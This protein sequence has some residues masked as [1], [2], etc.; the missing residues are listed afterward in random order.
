MTPLHRR[1]HLGLARAP[2]PAPSGSPVDA[3]VAHAPLDGAAAAEGEAW[4]ALLTVGALAL[5]QQ[6]GTRPQAGGALPPGPDLTQERPVAPAGARLLAQLLAG[7]HRELLP[8]A[9]ERLA[10]AGATLSAELLPAAL[11]CPDPALR[12]R[13]RPVL[14]PRGAWLAAQ[15]PAWA[16]LAGEPALADPEAAWLG[17]DIG[18]RE[19]A[20]RMLRRQDPQEGRVRLLA[21]WAG[22][23][24]E[25]RARLLPAL[26]E[27]LSMLDEPLL[28]DAL[29]D[30]ASAVRAAAARLL[31][32]LPASRWSLRMR[33]RAEDCLHHHAAAAGRL[34]RLLTGPSRVTLHPPDT[35]TRS[36]ARDGLTEPGEHG[37][38]AP[39]WWLVQIL[40]AVPP[41]HWQRRLRVEP[42]ALLA[43]LGPEQWPAVE[44]LS[45]AALSWPEAGWQLP[46]WRWWRA[47]ERGG[48]VRAGR[49]QHW[50][51]DLLRVLGAADAERLAL[52]LLR[53]PTLADASRLNAALERL[54]RPWPA[55][56][57][58][59]WL[60]G[61]HQSLQ[62]VAA[63]SP[64]E[65]LWWELSIQQAGVALPL[66]L[67]TWLPSAEP[68]RVA[69]WRG[70]IQ[71][72]RDQA[73]L[74]QRLAEE[75]HP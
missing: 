50:Q 45:R 36:L 31:A 24:P 26:E 25:D 74:R 8:E 39:E 7:Q 53:E 64:H 71:K 46:L 61:L 42:A 19:A 54:P 73:A 40:A 59:A 32:R 6:G 33:A 34:E 47:Q 23:R 1:L 9:L 38:G 21:S 27:G 67:L 3:L 4:R 65:L 56:V 55:G 37:L 58:R 16:W 30:R 69:R 17:V 68:L 60:T 43:L 70:L 20:L 13:L 44:G 10:Q 63:G 52:E 41:Q 15:N 18:A 2:E 62:A 66:P 48:K 11:S 51:D 14:G 22:E 57:G 72:L 28:E 49:T 75:I 29:D 35:F 5:W 12:E